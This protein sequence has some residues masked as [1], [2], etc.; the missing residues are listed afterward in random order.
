MTLVIEIDMCITYTECALQLGINL[1]LPPPSS[2]PTPS[3]R[4]EHGA[5]GDRGAALRHAR[6]RLVPH[7]EPG[8]DGLRQRG[9][10]QPRGSAGDGQATRRAAGEAGVHHGHTPR[11]QQQQQLCLSPPHTGPREEVD[12]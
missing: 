1:L 2:L 6:V 12:P 3:P 10:G 4:H 9:E 11:A 7:H 8:G 5:R